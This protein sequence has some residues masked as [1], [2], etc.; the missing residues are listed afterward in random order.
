MA[1]WLATT[2]LVGHGAA[3]VFQRQA[4]TS[5]VPVLKT[6]SCRRT[7]HSQLVGTQLKASYRRVVGCQKPEFVGAG[8]VW[9]GRCRIIPY[10]VG[11][12][13]MGEKGF[14]CGG[15]YTVISSEWNH[16]TG[17]IV[18]LVLVLAQCEIQERY[19]CRIL[20]VDGWMDGR[21]RS[22]RGGFGSFSFIVV[23]YQYRYLYLM[24]GEDHGIVTVDCAIGAG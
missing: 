8:T 2:V 13:K 6:G 4:G 21:E 7:G 3:T 20:S 15:A 11:G 18:V 23:S 17:I 14:V 22:V 1:G 5:T 12:I 16:S 24:R 10:A 19:G 9:Y